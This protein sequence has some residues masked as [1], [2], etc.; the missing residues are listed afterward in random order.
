MSITYAHLN[1]LERVGGRF[2]GTGAI[3]IQCDDLR[4]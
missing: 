3:P 4:R 2:L 1:N